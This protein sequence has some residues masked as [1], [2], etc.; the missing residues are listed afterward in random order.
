MTIVKIEK[1]VPITG[2]R[3]ESRRSKYPWDQM[4]IGD[5]FLFDAKV[6]INNGNAR[7]MCGLHSKN[8]K[9]FEYGRLQM[10]G[11]RIRCWRTE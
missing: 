8:G 9:K 6:T 1:N 11:G 3:I 4:E 5:S 2:A 10:D 7:T